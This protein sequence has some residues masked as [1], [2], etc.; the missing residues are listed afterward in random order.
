MDQ[1][2][3][4]I[5][6]TDAGAELVRRLNKFATVEAAFWAKA[7]EE[8]RWYLY[9]ASDQ[10]NDAN[11]DVAYGEVLRLAEEMANPHF[12]PFHVNLITT[13]DPLARAALDLLRRYPGL[14]PARL[15]ATNF[16]GLSVEDVYLYP[17][18]VVSTA[19]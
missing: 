11:M 1:G 13:S 4:V 15:G 8:S 2:P 17:P 5:E 12:D 18:S 16:G 7:S 19:S 10:L 9:I 6:A 14:M 3:L